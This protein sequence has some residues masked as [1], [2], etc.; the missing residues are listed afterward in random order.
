MLLKHG[1]ANEESDDYIKVRTRRKEDFHFINID[2]ELESSESVQPLI[3]ELGENILSLYCGDIDEIANLEL[4]LFEI[5][6]VDFYDTYDD[7]KDLFAVL[8]FILTSFAI[9]LRT[10]LKNHAEFGIIVIE[11]NLTLDFRREIHQKV[12]G[13]RFSR[14]QLK[15]VVNWAQQF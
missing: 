4:N 10:N 13:H 9:C 7:E 6:G 11:K 15:D 1:F 12:F 8:T 3:I 2:L 14:K 5:N